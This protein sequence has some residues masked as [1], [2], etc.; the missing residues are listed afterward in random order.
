MHL[1]DRL[2]NGDEYFSCHQTPRSDNLMYI[3]EIRIDFFRWCFLILFAT[4]IEA[5]N[6]M[7]IMMKGMKI[8]IMERSRSHNSEKNSRD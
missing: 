2:H 5:V 1:I 3:L 8:M 6:E 4:V 7:L